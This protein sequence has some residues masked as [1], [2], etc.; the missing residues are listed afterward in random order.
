MLTQYFL[1]FE[2]IRLGGPD[3]LF[4][5]C[6]RL[7]CVSAPRATLTRIS[8]DKRSVLVVV[9]ENI[10][11]SALSGHYLLKCVNELFHLP[12]LPDR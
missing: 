9:E 10:E 11:L 4:V 5:F 3:S 2:Q 12:F 7:W 1:S 8:Q 6:E